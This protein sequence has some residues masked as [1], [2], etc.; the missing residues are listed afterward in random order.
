MC[1]IISNTRETLLWGYIQMFKASRLVLWKYVIMLWFFSETIANDR[2]SKYASYSMIN[3]H[4]THWKSRADIC[5]LLLRMIA[6]HPHHIEMGLHH[7]RGSKLC[8]TQ[9]A[10]SSYIDRDNVFEFSMVQE[11]TS[12][13][14]S[15][16]LRYCHHF[17]VLSKFTTFWR[18]R[19]Y[20]TGITAAQ[21]RLRWSLS[22]MG[23]E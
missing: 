2:K 22:I 19:S 4:N 6:R 9:C 16:P 5:S 7:N 21:L 10:V 8:I 17:S 12:R 15:H 3:E 14:L 18:S 11:W 23:V 20:L 1:A 13:S